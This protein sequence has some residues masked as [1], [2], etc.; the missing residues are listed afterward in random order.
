MISMRKINALYNK[1]MKNFFYNPFVAVSP[2][3]M[4]LLAYLQSTILPYD[5]PPEAF[6]G[7]LIMVVLMNVLM[8]GGF[9]MS[10]LIA[11]EK[12]KF[13][14]NVLITS[15]VSVLDFFISNVLTVATITIVTNVAIYFV[16]GVDFISFAAFLAVTSLGVVA[17][18]A[19]GASFGLLAKNQAAA[20]A[21]S[22]PFVLIV[23]LPIFFQDNFFVD[24]VLYYF[25]TEQVGY[26]LLNLAS[27]GEFEWVRMGIITA[28]FIVLLAFFAI[29]YKKRGLEN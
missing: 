12:E 8:T 28:N 29:L 21:M 2:V 25:F 24:N 15:T 17:A 16:M 10:C 26:T 22:T 3:L 20:S 9:T 1:Q 6:A 11:E 7:M 13:T 27:T 19:M 18:I 14:L 4:I 23:I 5:A